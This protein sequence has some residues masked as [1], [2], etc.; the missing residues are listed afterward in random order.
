[1]DFPGRVTGRG[2]KEERGGRSAVIIFQLETFKMY[3]QN[4]ELYSF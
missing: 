1:M 4:K 3:D 2:L